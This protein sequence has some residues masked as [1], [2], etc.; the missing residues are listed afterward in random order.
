MLC[1]H[2]CIC[3]QFSYVVVFQW[4]LSLKLYIIWLGWR[5][6]MGI[7]IVSCLFF[8][9]HRCALKQFRKCEDLWSMGNSISYTCLYDVERAFMFVHVVSCGIHTKSLFPEN[10]DNLVVIHLETS[11]NRRRSLYCIYTCCIRW[12]G[13]SFDDRCIR[14]TFYFNSVVISR[15]VPGL[16]IDLPFGKSVN[17]PH[18]FCWSIIRFMVLSK[19]WCV[20]LLK[21]RG[22]LYRVQIVSYLRLDYSNNMHAYLTHGLMQ[23]IWPDLS[24]LWEHSERSK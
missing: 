22:I 18:A 4:T 2:I 12:T 3:L 13:I 11:V 16:A 5:K 19:C 14:A 17:D 23:M 20:N 8:G 6:D 7:W 15:S 21:W 1:I 24:V 10:L 9:T